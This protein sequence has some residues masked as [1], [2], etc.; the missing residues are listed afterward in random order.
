MNS[1][2][3]LQL[4]DLEGLGTELWHNFHNQGI[5]HTISCGKSVTLC[6]LRG[7]IL[8][9]SLILLT[10]TKGEGGKGGRGEGGAVGRNFGGV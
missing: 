4:I 7:L 2:S 6:L 10:H 3:L 9:C 8:S 1:L 5:R